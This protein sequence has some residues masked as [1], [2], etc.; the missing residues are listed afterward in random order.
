MNGLFCNTLKIY[1]ACL[2]NHND[3][4]YFFNATQQILMAAFSL[5]CIHRDLA[6][7]NI[8]VGEEKVMKIADFGL[9]R[10]VHEI[11]YYRKTTD[12]GFNIIQYCFTIPQYDIQYSLV[13]F[14]SKKMLW[15][16]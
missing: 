6:A 13:S 10:D 15:K 9:A 14:F 11:D 2:E 1:V 12:V 16:T 8:L 3:W 7:R 5:Q 4:Y